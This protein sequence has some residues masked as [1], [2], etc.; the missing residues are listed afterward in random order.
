MMA[1]LLVELGLDLDADVVAGNGLSLWPPDALGHPAPQARAHFLQLGGAAT[2]AGIPRATSYTPAALQLLTSLSQAWCSIAVQK[3]G[4]VLLHDA[5]L[6]DTSVSRA[7]AIKKNIRYLSLRMLGVEATDDDVSKIYDDVYTKY[8][9][10][11]TAVAW[12]AVCAALV[13]SPEW[14]F[15]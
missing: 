7:D 2:L 11:S 12:T 13:R 3:T 5:T 6:A 15:L 4:S 8:E 14:L 10:E 1:S 9:P